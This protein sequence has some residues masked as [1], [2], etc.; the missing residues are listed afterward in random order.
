MASRLNVDTQSSGRAK[1]RRLVMK[2]PGISKD[3]ILEKLGLQARTSTGE[4]LLGAF[5]FFGIGLVV[6]AATALLLA[7]K[8]GRELRSDITAKA[9]SLRGQTAEQP[10]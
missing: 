9:R 10:H 8:S 5:G 4:W 2:I 3:D 6:G 1:E 7:P